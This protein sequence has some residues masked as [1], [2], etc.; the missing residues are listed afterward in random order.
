M[1]D[2]KMIHF[3]GH[4]GTIEQT[5]PF[6]FP[7]N[8]P[9]FNYSNLRSG[10]FPQP[11]GW[12][13]LKVGRDCVPPTTDH[14]HFTGNRGAKPWRRPPPNDMHMY[15]M[16]LTTTATPAITPMSPSSA[17]LLVRTPTPDHLWWQIW[18]IIQQEYNIS[19]STVV[20]GRWDRR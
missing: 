6:T 19:L 11:G 7:A 1:F 13:R 3:N 4:D 5:I 8:N 17:S 15:Y 2:K 16:N 18:D 14:A 20:G 10:R 12:C 9:L